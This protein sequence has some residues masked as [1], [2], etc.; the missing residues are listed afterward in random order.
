MVTQRNG[1]GVVVLRQPT[2]VAVR[3][4]GWVAAL[5]LF[6]A[7]AWVTSRG[8][9]WLT[10]DVLGR[11]I[12]PLPRRDLVVLVPAFFGFFMP[13]LYAGCSALAGRWLR[14]RVDTMVLYVG[15]T[16]CC[17]VWAE[18]AADELFV[19]LLGRPGWVYHV[20]P[21]HHGYTSGVG[22][23]MWPMYGFFVCL[24]HEAIH[25]SPRLAFLD[26]DVQRAVLVAL[27]AMV[28]EVAANAFTLLG[29]GSYFFHYHAGDLVHFTT[30]EIFVPYVVAGALGLQLLKVLER[31]AP[32]VPTG[33]V[34]FAVGV[35]SV[36]LQPPA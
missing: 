30:W 14:P 31:R 36:L 5:V 23:V 22:L 13:V 17:A 12:T 28:L 24:L 3:V 35:L 18:I 8:V 33:V 32:K 2:A 16:L 21:V 6:Y 19:L 27:D 25:V 34:L 7:G 1:G 11:T 15:T 29:F 4:A 10:V 26:G 9:L 20:W